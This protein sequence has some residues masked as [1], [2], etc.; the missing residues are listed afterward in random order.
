MKRLAL[1]I[2]TLFLLTFA[3]Q[4]QTPDRAM[5]EGPV[6]RIGEYRAKP[7]KGADYVKYLREHAMPLLAEQKRQG[8]IL[9]YKFFTNV[10]T[11]GPQEVQYVQA[12]L[13]RNFA[14]ALDYNAEMGKKFNDI[15]LKHFGSAENRTKVNEQMFAIREFIRGYLLREMTI[16]PLKAAGQ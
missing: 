6:W 8:L 5:T 13:H 16:H 7:G 9:D 10:T 15:S 11:A 12:I 2:T 4:A 3:A 14:D 1:L